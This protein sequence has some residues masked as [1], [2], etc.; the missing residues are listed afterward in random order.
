MPLIAMTVAVGVAMVVLLLP[1][2]L[3]L[4]LLLLQVLLL[5]II[6]A[7]RL[8]R[9]RSVALPWRAHVLERGRRT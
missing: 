9:F 1:L 6:L 2:L 4:W 5:W 7:P 8:L 3:L